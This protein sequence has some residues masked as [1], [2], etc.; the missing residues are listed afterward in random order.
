MRYGAASVDASGYVRAVG[1]PWSDGWTGTAAQLLPELRRAAKVPGRQ[2]LRVYVV[3]MGAVYRAL[4]RAGV[5]LGAA[6][7]TPGP[8]GVGRIV[9]GPRVQLSGCDSILPSGVLSELPDDPAA[10][11]AALIEARAA[12]AGIGAE[13][14]GSLTAAAVDLVVAAAPRFGYPEP[15]GGPITSAAHEAIHAGLCEIWQDSEAL[16]TAGAA[17]VPVDWIGSPERLPDGW[18]IRDEDRVSAYAAEACGMLPAVHGPA[19]DDPDAPGGALVLADIDLDGWAGVALPVRVAYGSQVVHLA[20]TAG[21]W[22][23]WYTSD[24]I[25]YARARGAS[26]KVA[27]AFGWKSAQPFLRPGM[28]LIANGKAQHARGTTARAV[29]SAAAQRVVGGMARRD[30]AE[31]I[32][33]AAQLDS[34]TT[35]DLSAAGYVARLGRLDGWELV[36]VAPDPAVPRGTCP[37]WTAFV[38]SRAWVT[39]CERI[40]AVRAVGGR[41]L[42]A[43]TD[44]LCWAAPPG[45]Q[46]ECGDQLG[47]WQLRGL[48]EWAWIEARKIYAR[49]INQKITAAASA[50]IPRAD[51]VWYLDGGGAPYRWQTLREQIA[52]NQTEPQQVKVWTQRTERMK[53]RAQTPRRLRPQPQR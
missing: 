14:R 15:Q 38:V 32:I 2:H 1:D 40:E 12:L 34:M 13:L 51:L 5:E 31:R 3:D 47:Q 17:G 20:A 4:R 39:M 35:D 36:R 19:Y 49:G 46:L 43:D 22:R 42:Y 7:L 52:Q 30:P 8:Q 27:Q 26:V 41:P 53:A 11:Y 16:A 44:G 25:R 29:L 23:G 9:A 18:T 28:M 10:L 50:G 37:V 33:D 48:P 6:D 21:A 24:L 45:A